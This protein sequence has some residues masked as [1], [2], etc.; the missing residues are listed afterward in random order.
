L[1]RSC[2]TR[3][4]IGAS[5]KSRK[6]AFRVLCGL[7]VRTTVNRPSSGM[8]WTEIPNIL[9]DYHERFRRE[10]NQER[11]YWFPGT[12]LLRD[13]SAVDVDVDP[14]PSSSLPLTFP[15]LR[16]RF[17]C[18]YRLRLHFLLPS[19]ASVGTSLGSGIAM[20]MDGGVDVGVDV[21]VEGWGWPWMS[22]GCG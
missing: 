4:T 5:I 1:A 14:L 2:F 22:I 18:F 8:R 20:V 15:P 6:N 7:A 16:A 19:F 13:P 10:N 12:F 21:G 3:A 17:S 9:G 11:T